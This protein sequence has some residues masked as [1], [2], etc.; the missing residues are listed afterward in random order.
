MQQLPHATWQATLHLQVKEG[1]RTSQAGRARPPAAAQ[2][3]TGVLQ[4]S[5]VSRDSRPA[6]EAAALQL[7][8]TMYECRGP[9]SSGSRSSAQRVMRG[10]VRSIL[11]LK[12]L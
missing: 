11:L 9:A 3:R 12:R 2:P 5:P 4:F 1:R 8:G 7:T 10:G 6:Q